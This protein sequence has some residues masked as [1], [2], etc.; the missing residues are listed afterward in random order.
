MSLASRLA[1]RSGSRL[2]KSSLALPAASSGIE[3]CRINS[4]VVC[5]IWYCAS[6]SRSLSSRSLRNALMNRDSQDISLPS[7]GALQ[8]LAH[9][10]RYHA[11]AGF[12]LGKLFPAGSCDLVKPGPAIVLR[13]YPFSFDPATLFHAVQRRIKGTLLHVKDV[14]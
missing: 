5:S 6:S 11:P 3:P 9:S 4:A 13:L 12:F 10:G 2:P 1:S 14:V 8:D 7:L